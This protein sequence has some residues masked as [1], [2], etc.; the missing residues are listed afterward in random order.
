MYYFA[1]NFRFISE[2]EEYSKS[3]KQVAFVAP[4]SLGST[5][6]NHQSFENYKCVQSTSLITGGQK[7]RLGEFPHM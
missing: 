7:T 1:K 5:S 2:C 6:A 3:T 4:L